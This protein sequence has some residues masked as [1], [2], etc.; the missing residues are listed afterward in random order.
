MPPV[1]ALTI[2]VSVIAPRG[3]RLRD[4]S[5]WL[6]LVAITGGFWYLRNAA[7]IGNPV[8]Y[9]LHLGPISLP[10]PP[11][12]APATSVATFLFNGHDWSAYSC[13]AS[14]RHSDRPGGVSWA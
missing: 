8:P 4:T 3:R 2:G 5:L 1:L 11:G 12:L 14:A 13:P 9:A 7:A 6:L 10:S